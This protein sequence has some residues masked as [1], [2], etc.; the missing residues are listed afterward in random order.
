M[1]VTVTVATWLACTAVAYADPVVTWTA[2]ADEC[3]D[4]AAFIARVEA[5]FGGALDADLTA[6]VTATKTD[7]GWTVRIETTT[8][9]ATG[10]RTIEGATCAE[11]FDAAAL[12]V[13]MAVPPKISSP[14]PPPEGEG[15]RPPPP[16]PQP[17]SPPPSPPPPPP[18]LPVHIS[19]RIVV[20]S[21][22]G[23]LPGADPGFAAAFAVSRGR[24]RGE[25][26]ASTWLERSRSVDTDDGVRGADLSLKAAGL[27]AC[28]LPAAR[29]WTCAAGE[30][31]SMRG[32]GFGADDDFDRSSTWLAG[33]AS[34]VAPFSLS[35]SFNIVVIADA[36][37]PI[38]RPRFLHDGPVE[39]YQPAP[40]I[41]RLWV[42][43]AVQFR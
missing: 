30:L 11:V 5:H 10:E 40:V 38:R 43:A 23:M 25:V 29:V 9:D 32:I 34:A 22:L 16:P 41:G 37:A 14:P 6:T 4:E 42:G 20:G 19:A 1:R 35:R 12:V 15:D 26:G 2:P 7:P 17:P 27:R 8:G 36:L 28:Y 33:G 3:P 13:A 31:G 18:P 24:L 39:V 21:N